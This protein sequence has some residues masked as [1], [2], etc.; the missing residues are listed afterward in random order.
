MSDQNS[1]LSVPSFGEFKG[2]VNDK[3]QLGKARTF[4]AT[5][6]G[7]APA[8]IKGKKFKEVKEMLVASGVDK[9]TIK[10]A[11]KEFDGHR[12]TYWRQVNSYNAMLAA[13]PRFRKS[14]KI[15]KQANG[16]IAANVTY[17]VTPKLAESA[18][19]RADNAER[20][21][22]TLRAEIATLRG[23]QLPA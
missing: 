16:N 20:E 4:I 11:Q 6:F 10:A 17:R 9:D 14:M 22:A 23:A 15:W 13:D 1:Q 19:Q 12:Q 18:N 2:A 5:K 8:A 7:L 3:G 21:L